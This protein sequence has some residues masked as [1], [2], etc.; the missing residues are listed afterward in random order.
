[1]E[2]NNGALLGVTALVGACMRMG[3]ERFDVSLRSKNLTGEDSA[4]W[5]YRYVDAGDNFKRNYTGGGA[6]RYLLRRYR[7]SQNPVTRS[8]RVTGCSRETS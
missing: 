6:A 1:M 5:G 2:S 4:I 8:E 3:T 7:K